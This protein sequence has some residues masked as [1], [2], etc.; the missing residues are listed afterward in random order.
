MEAGRRVYAALLASAVVLSLIA[1][2][3]LGYS[4]SPSTRNSRVEALRREVEDLKVEASKLKDAVQAL[5]S[6]IQNVSARLDEANRS[7]SSKI[8]LVAEK[9][10]GLEDRLT[11]LQRSISL[12]GANLTRIY[13]EVRD[14]VVLVRCVEAYETPFGTAYRSKQGSGFIYGYKGRNLVVT[15]FHVVS[16]S[17]DVTVRLSDGS[18]YPAQL[19]GSD[20]YADLAVLSVELSTGKL[21]PLELASSSLLK[22]GEPV[23]VVGNP[24][25]L[26]AS[27][28]VGVVSQVGRAIPGEMTGGFPLADMV[29]I[30]VPI[31]PGDSGAPLLNLEGKVVGVTTAIVAGSQGVGFAV[32]SDTILRELPYLVENG[33][34]DMH[35]W[36]GALGVDMS[37]A[38][39]KAMGVNVTYGW[40]IV[41]VVEDSPA[42]KAGL[43]G[44]TREVQIEGETLLIG[45]DIIVAVDGFRIVDGDSLASYLER[46]TTP[47]Q[48][49]TFTVV[50]EGKPIE[51]EVQL[52]RRPAFKP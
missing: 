2:V 46:Y 8:G 47:G 10:G 36:L 41:E 9:L 48:T 18:S 3:F 44:G 42:Y 15:N 37:Y 17:V 22:I 35:P 12:L 4:F 13:M 7:L 50:R 26:T 51:V 28:R 40:L 32:P 25:G 19:L 49:V 52:G 16:G 24:F 29:Q 21:K 1:G 20:P 31:N 38:I 39:A 23:V 14:S 45:G 34:Y 43:R 6:A 11:S 5:S 27:F 33:S 30:T